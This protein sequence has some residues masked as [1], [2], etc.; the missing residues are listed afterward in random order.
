MR[1]KPPSYFLP[2]SLFLQFFS[3]SH[4]R[5]FSSHFFEA[6]FL[7]LS[8]FLFD[9]GSSASTWWLDSREVDGNG[10]FVCVGVLVLFFLSPPAF[11]PSD[12]PSLDRRQDDS[13]MRDEHWKSTWKMAKSS[14]QQK[15]PGLCTTSATHANHCH[16]SRNPLR[17][18]A[19]Y[20]ISSAVVWST[21]KTWPRRSQ[22]GENFSGNNMASWQSLQL[23]AL[24][25]ESSRRHG[26][27]TRTTLKCRLAVIVDPAPAIAPCSPP[28][29]APITPPRDEAAKFRNSAGCSRPTE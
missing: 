14:K 29:P 1:F 5:L 6:L 26:S 20:S 18:S 28:L 27:C 16:H 23:F 12:S 11:W 22:R 8:F 19:T 10:A 7:R 17:S 4:N 13:Q 24:L 25:A 15:C 2:F 9:G 3:F 21:N